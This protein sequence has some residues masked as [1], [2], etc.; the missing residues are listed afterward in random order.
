MFGLTQK[1]PRVKTSEKPL[2]VDASDEATS[3]IEGVS[4]VNDPAFQP[5]TWRLRAVAVVFVAG[6]GA[7]FLA[8]ML[9]NYAII[10]WMFPEARNLAGMASILD[11]FYHDP[12]L[13]AAIENPVKICAVV[14]VRSAAAIG[15]V[16]CLRELLP[17]ASMR[18]FGFIRPTMKQIGFGVVAGCGAVLASVAVQ[19][20]FSLVAGRHP[21]HWTLVVSTHHGLLAYLLD[22][23]QGSVATPL[24]EETLFRGL[25]FA[26]L[27]QRI[28]P[29]PA[30]LVSAIIFGLC[31]LSPYELPHLI[32]AGLIMAYVYYRTRNIW[33]A[34]MAHAVVNGI[35]FTLIYL[36]EVLPH[37]S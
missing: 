5:G 19:G 24:A 2:R 28:G 25:L 16:Y 23:F 14:S 20:A 33:A 36:H 12:A 8:A 27:L 31:H 9:A 1:R 18:A 15:T 11:R 6:V 21:N 34:M 7:F 29:V 17:A 26:G 35:A 10:A 32:T 30:A 3:P 22:I 37:H 13:R 4:S